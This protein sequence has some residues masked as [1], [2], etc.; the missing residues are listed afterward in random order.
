M[1]EKKQID[2]LYFALSPQ[3]IMKKDRGRSIIFKLDERG[4]IEKHQF[5][6]PIIAVMLALFTP[7]KPFHR[8]VEEL[9]FITK[10]PL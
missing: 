1:R 3:V 6:H 4:I 5:I 8:V 9:S 2:E 10:T 7:D